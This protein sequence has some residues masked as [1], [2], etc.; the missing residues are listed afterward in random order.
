MDVKS[1][2]NTLLSYIFSKK[3]VVTAVFMSFFIAIMWYMLWA[4]SISHYTVLVKDFPELRI[5]LGFGFSMGLIL[6]LG[7]LR[8][9]PSTKKLKY[10]GERFLGYSAVFTVLVLNSADVYVY[11]FPDK[12]IGYLSEYDVEFPGPARGKSG[13]C[14]AG[15]WIKDTNT[16]RWKELCTSKAALLVERRQGMDA[17]WVTARVNKLGSYIVNYEF[18]YK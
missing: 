12:T 14:E 10:L 11:L 2:I 4:T 9:L 13:H 1:K 8:H 3:F 15:L 16:D 17:V 18:V 7:S 6:T 5:Y